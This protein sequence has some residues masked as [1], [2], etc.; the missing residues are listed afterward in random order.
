MSS[1]ACVGWSHRLKSFLTASLS[2][3]NQRGFRWARLINRNDAASPAFNVSAH[4]YAFGTDE[5]G[6]IEV[7]PQ[8]GTAKSSQKILSASDLAGVARVLIEATNKVV[9]APFAECRFA[10]LPI[11]HRS[12]TPPFA[13]SLLRER[14]RTPSR[15][16]CDRA[17]HRR[18]RHSGPA[19]RARHEKLW[20]GWQDRV[21]RDCLASRR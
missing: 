7:G 9:N 3:W 13:A 4:A 1:A 6:A 19:G 2:C 5:G 17:G 18:A 8:K 11:V 20:R 10:V 15:P 14:P 12:L 21:H 16:E